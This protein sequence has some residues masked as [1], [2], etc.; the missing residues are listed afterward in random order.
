MAPTTFQP[1]I[2]NARKTG[3]RE[4]VLMRWSL[5]PHFAKSAADFKGISTIDA[6]AETDEFS[7]MAS[8]VSTSPLPRSRMVARFAHV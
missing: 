5:V 3:E 8:T 4:L 2:R 7:H 1:V 6:K